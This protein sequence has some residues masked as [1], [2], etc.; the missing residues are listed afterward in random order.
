MLNETAMRG[1]QSGEVQLAGVGSTWWSSQ[2]GKI[3][4]F[5][6]ATVRMSLFEFAAVRTLHTPWG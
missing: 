2:L 3:T 6:V 4:C 5:E 1:A